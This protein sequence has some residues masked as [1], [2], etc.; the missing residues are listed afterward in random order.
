VTVARL[1]AN[2]VVETYCTGD[3]DAAKAWM[4]GEFDV[5]PATAVTIN[6]EEQ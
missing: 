2:G 5:N 4:A 3:M 1:G 6:L